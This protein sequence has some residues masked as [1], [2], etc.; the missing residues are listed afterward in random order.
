MDGPRF[1]P[2]RTAQ[3]WAVWAAW[4]W[5]LFLP[6]RNGYC[7]SVRKSWSGSAYLPHR[8]GL[9]D[10]CPWSPRLRDRNGVRLAASARCSWRAF[11]RCRA[12]AWRRRTPRLLA[13]WFLPYWG[14]SCWAAWVPTRQAV[15]AALSWH[16]M[17]P[18]SELYHPW[19]AHGWGSAGSQAAQ[20]S[21]GSAG[22][23][24]RGGCSG[25]FGWNCWTQRWP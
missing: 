16:S 5:T 15:P 9:R 4:S 7:W 18:G 21:S 23:G 19:A 6:D 12:G 20:S 22:P 11:L 10:L 2:C 1:L 14:G 24:G 17:Y 3:H 25:W 13:F 8:A